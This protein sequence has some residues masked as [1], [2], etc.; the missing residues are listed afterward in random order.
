M[1]FDANYFVT[2]SHQIEKHGMLKTH[3]TILLDEM[4]L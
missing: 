1:P 2:N 3:E 4:I